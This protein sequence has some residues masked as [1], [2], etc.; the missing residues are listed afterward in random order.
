MSN[1]SY[2]KGAGKW[3]PE[4]DGS[5]QAEMAAIHRETEAPEETMTRLTEMELQDELN[6]DI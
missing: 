6:P 5:Y 3:C 1:W 4:N 2:K